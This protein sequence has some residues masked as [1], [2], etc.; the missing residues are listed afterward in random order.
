MAVDGLGT[1]LC[2]LTI[3][4]IDCNPMFFNHHQKLSKYPAIQMP[5][6]SSLQLKALRSA[7]VGA[8]RR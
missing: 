8:E 2:A 7:D 6:L 4:L 3:I 5:S 1:L